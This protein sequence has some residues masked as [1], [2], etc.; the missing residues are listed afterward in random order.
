MSEF[1]AKAA[2]RARRRSRMVIIVLTAIFVGGISAGVG[3]D[4]WAGTAFAVAVAL[5]MARLTR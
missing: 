4:F 1:F 5:V 2:L 3:L